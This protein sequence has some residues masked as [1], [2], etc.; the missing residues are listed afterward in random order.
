M[1]YKVREV[2]YSLKINNI[3]INSERIDS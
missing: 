3:E 1:I 2:V